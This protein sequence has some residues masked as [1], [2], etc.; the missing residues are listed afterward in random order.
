ME[1][2]RNKIFNISSATMIG[3]IDYLILS[4]DISLPNRIKQTGEEMDGNSQEP[5]DCDKSIRIIAG[6]AISEEIASKLL[7]SSKRI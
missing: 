7:I 1:L 5:S 2:L 3:Q 4:Y 6:S